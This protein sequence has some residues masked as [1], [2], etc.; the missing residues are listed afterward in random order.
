MVISSEAE[1]DLFFL[2]TILF[3]YKHANIYLQICNYCY[4][5][6]FAY[7]CYSNWQVF[8]LMSFTKDGESYFS[9]RLNM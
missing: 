8:Q 4:S 7:I 5:F 1:H 3:F 2:K 6:L 9:K